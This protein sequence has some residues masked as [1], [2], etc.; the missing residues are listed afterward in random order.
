[1]PKS[2]IP[3]EK[4]YQALRSSEEQSFFLDY[5]SSG[6]LIL[7]L[8]L[9]PSLAISVINGVPLTLV[10]RN[11]LIE[12]NSITL[13]IN[14][15]VDAPFWISKIFDD[16]QDNLESKEI[17]GLV[18]YAHYFET[19]N[20]IRIAIYDETLKNIFIEDTNFEIPYNTLFSWYQ[21]ILASKIIFNDSN[22][23]QEGNDP[24]NELTGYRIKINPIQYSDSVQYMNFQTR[25]KWGE[26]PY[27]IS[28][29]KEGEWYTVDNYNKTGKTGYLQEQN[30]REILQNFY[31]PNLQLFGSPKL[32]TTT[33]NSAEELTDIVFGIN[34]YLILLESKATVSFS[35]TESTI[36]SRERAVTNLINKACKQLRKAEK[37]V[38]ENPLNLESRALSEYCVYARFIVKICIINDVLQINRRSL[39][40]SLSSYRRED[41]PVIMSLDTFYKILYYLNNPAE[42]VKT[43]FDIKRHLDRKQDL[44]I[45]TK[46]S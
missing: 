25:N 19:N 2:H 22:F 30:I 36:K 34:G 26:K 46:L 4:I 18:N 5:D 37:I 15:L 42:I 1:M 28:S 16:G 27:V 45:L 9:Y 6:I 38:R 44:P 12:R 13:Y 35:G 7:Y 43:L 21:K 17:S 29:N 33:K 41:L 40:S 10:F 8:K 23:W 24:E 3:G 20:K 14:D 31:M 39:S 32:K 11:P